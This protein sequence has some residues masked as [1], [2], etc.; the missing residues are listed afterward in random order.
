MCL[1]KVITLIFKKGYFMR[2]SE[3]CKLETR[4]RILE[5]GAEIFAC[6]GFDATT[7]RDIAQA[8]GLAA[9]TDQC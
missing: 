7:T 4:I 2:I 1:A 3:Q 9:G 8:A 5:K 6:K